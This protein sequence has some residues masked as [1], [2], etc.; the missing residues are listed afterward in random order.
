MR[1]KKAIS[2]LDKWFPPC[3]PCAFCGFKDKRH[4][5]WDIFLDAPETDAELAKDFDYPIEAIQA[6][7]QIRPYRQGGTLL[8]NHEDT[9]DAK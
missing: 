5:L 9:E 4:L 7:R 6:V 2:Q 8:L 1:S 3:G